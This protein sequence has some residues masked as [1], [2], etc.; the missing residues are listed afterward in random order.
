[1]IDGDLPI[2]SPGALLFCVLFAIGA[3]AVFAVYR[4]ATPLSPEQRWVEA[5]SQRCSAMRSRLT[6]D[7]AT[8]KAECYRTPF[9]RR[10]KLEFTVTYPG[11]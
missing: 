2:F 4:L 7:R 3:G 9:M 1:M 8:K 10:P 11:D 5:Q 6:Y